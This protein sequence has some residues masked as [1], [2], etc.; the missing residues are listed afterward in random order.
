MAADS[1]IT[2]T[3]TDTKAELRQQLAPEQ[4]LGL[5]GQYGQ[6]LGIGSNCFLAFTL[7]VLGESEKAAKYFQNAKGYANASNHINSI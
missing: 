1:R 2:D 4:H 3:D 7:E 6:D 5:E